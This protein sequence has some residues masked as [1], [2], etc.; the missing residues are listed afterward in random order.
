MANTQ[1]TDSGG[2][3]Y[4]VGIDIG[5]TFTDGILI[6]GQGRVHHFKTPSVP[7]NPSEAFMQCLTKA[8]RFLDIS[9]ENLLPRISKLS[10][11]NTIATNALLEHKVAKTGLI[12][13]RGFRDVL[14]I[15]R[16]GR[17][18]LGIDLQ[19]QRPD[20]LVP[21]SRIEEITERVDSRGEVVTPLKEAEI[22]EM[23]DS[24]A[25]ADI[26]AIAVCLL[27]SFKNPEHERKI[28]RAIVERFPG[29]YFSLS[30]E[31]APIIGEYERTATTVINASLGPLLKSHLGTLSEE[32]EKGGLNVPLLLMQATGG[33][34][35]TADAAL[36]PITMVNSGPAGGVIAGKYLSELLGMPNCICVDMGGTSLDVSLI[37]E[38]QYSASLSAR[39][40][41]NNVVVPMLD[42]FCIGAGGGSIAWLDGGRRLKVGPQSAG[43]NPGPSCY[44]RGGTEPTVTD[45][46]VVLGR[47][48]PQFFLGGEILL[49]K[50][51]AASAIAEK[52]ARPLGLDLLVAAE[53]I[54]RIVDANMADAVRTMTLRQGY[55][56]RDYALIAFGGAGP[57]HAAA[58][59]QELG[60]KTIVIP[61]MAAVQSAFGIVQSDITHSLTLGDTVE[62]GDLDKITRHF[63][64]LEERGLDLLRKD[65]IREEQ[66]EM[67]RWVDMHYRG[68]AH[69]VTVPLLARPS[70]REDIKG[71]IEA[72]E[73]K[74]ESIY[75]KGT[76]FS[77]AGYE[78]AVFRVDAVGKT[79]KPD[80]PACVPSGPDSSPALKGYRQLF[81]QGALTTVPVYSGE[82][83]KTGNVVPGPCIV[84]YVDTT[85]I[86][87]ANMR[88]TMDP[89]RNLILHSEA[90]SCEA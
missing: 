81:F 33:V 84:E 87:N 70:S 63:T 40:S 59:A 4:Y 19:C 6:D 41:D 50:D 10:Y 45:A 60:I 29:M 88:A 66:M 52:I 22:G 38:G 69:E 68:Q 18:Y 55:D 73:R 79:K 67:R 21:R 85:A 1:T 13:T 75:G 64:E 35:P 76:A 86:I 25:A 14:A 30:H 48:D 72:F 44:G 43:S 65:G 31:V 89:Y 58:I 54:C 53:G 16:I 9:L 34:V 62:I 28:G 27:W 49:D 90:K 24:F 57:V 46:D 5:G 37:T 2:P 15:A 39:I 78:I 74:Y 42:I 56:P 77:Q 71:I 32:L 12:T 26:S 51:K 20:P 82:K 80:T 3:E 23:L 7:S 8:A 17:E 61:S 83:L 47:I 11:G 36:M